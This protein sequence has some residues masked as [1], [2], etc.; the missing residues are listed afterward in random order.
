[1]TDANSAVVDAIL[2]LPAKLDPLRAAA[3]TALPCVRSRPRLPALPR[4]IDR[5]FA[6]ATN[7]AASRKQRVETTPAAPEASSPALLAAYGALR[8]RRRDRIS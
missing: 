4:D 3:L 6:A 1:V 2:P 7:G 5:L 8:Q